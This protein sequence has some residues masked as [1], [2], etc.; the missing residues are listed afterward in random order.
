MRSPLADALGVQLAPVAIVLTDQRPD[1]GTQFKPAS[2]GCVAA[3]LL[4]AAKGRT[5]FFDRDTFGC[6]GG[7]AGLGF[8]DCYERMGFPIDRLL[9]TGGTAQ[10]A[11]GGNYDM[12]EGERFH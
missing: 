7:G 2:M 9:S 8:G 11:N 10:L 4:S 5:A 6:P 12:R 1:E 3:M